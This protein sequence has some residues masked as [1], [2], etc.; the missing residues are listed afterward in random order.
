LDS[1]KFKPYEI[2]TIRLER[3]GKRR[4]VALIEEQ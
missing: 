1:L 4:E 3:S 2:K